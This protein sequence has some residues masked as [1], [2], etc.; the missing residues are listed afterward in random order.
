MKEHENS[1][2]TLN[3]SV[4]NFA[5]YSLLRNLCGGQ[6]ATRYFLSDDSVAVRNHRLTICCF[7][8][9]L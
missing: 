5:F 3:T 4:A 1:S 8:F 6:Y 9:G 7:C 2:R